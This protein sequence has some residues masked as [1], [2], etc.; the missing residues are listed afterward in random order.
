MFDFARRTS[1]RLTFGEELDSRPVWSPDG[2]R[3]AYASRRAS[4]TDIYVKASDGDGRE[5]PLLVSS[6]PKFPYD[7]SRDGKYLLYTGNVPTPRLWALPMGE[8]RKPQLL[9]TSYFREG[10]GKFSPDGRLVAYR[11]DE[12]GTNEIYVRPFTDPSGGKWMISTGESLE[13]R[14]RADGRELFYLSGNRIVAVDVTTTPTFK[15]GVPKILFEAPISTVGQTAVHQYDVTADGKK[16]LV[17]RIMGESSL[18]EISVVL[19]W[20]ASLKR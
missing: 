2:K 1:S 10:Q 3:I 20:P 9:F 19:N 15:A 12:S 11:S 8:K 4:V 6:E 5:E 14:W 13:P 17:N 18:P 7:W 16:F